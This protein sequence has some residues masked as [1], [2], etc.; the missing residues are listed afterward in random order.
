M[1]RKCTPD[2][3]NCRCSISWTC[4]FY[5]SEIL[6]ISCC[7]ACQTG[8]FVVR[9]K[10]CL[11]YSYLCLLFISIVMYEK[12]RRDSN[13]LTFGFRL[14]NCG[15]KM[16]LRAFYFII[17]LTIT[18]AY[19]KIKRTLRY[20]L[21]TIENNFRRHKLFTIRGCKSDHIAQIFKEILRF[22]IQAK[23]I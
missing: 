15:Q 20:L 5:A 13:S 1:G 18:L 16:A 22:N 2:R 19:Y 3:Q 6:W 12:R 8:T 11:S 17:T 21:A 7:V 9:N 14:I 23:H 4:S 10:R